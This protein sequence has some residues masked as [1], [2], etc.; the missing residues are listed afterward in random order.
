[1]S[2][3]IPTET[4]VVNTDEVVKEPILDRIKRIAKK[5]AIPAALAVGGIVTITV[6]S[7]N[8][9]VGQLEDSLIT[10]DELEATLSD[11]HEV[12]D[13]EVIED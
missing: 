5:A 7:L 9:R 8:T 4:P 1:M 2:N 12:L 13:A 3:Q 10:L 11:D 6:A